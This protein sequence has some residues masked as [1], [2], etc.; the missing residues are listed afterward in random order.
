MALSPLKKQRRMAEMASDC[1]NCLWDQGQGCMHPRSETKVTERGCPWFERRGG[2]SAAPPK[3]RSQ[4]PECVT[5][6]MANGRH[7]GPKANLGL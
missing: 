6:E 4:S 2:A 7:S 3:V 5:G 1:G